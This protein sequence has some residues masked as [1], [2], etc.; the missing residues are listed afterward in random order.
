MFIESPS[1]AA[2]QRGATEAGT[3]Q[4]RSDTAAEPLLSVRNLNVQF[5]SNDR[6]LHIVRDV[7]YDVHAGELVA[8]V[9]E[10][11]C[12]KS[13]SSLAVM[14][15]LPDPQTARFSGEVRLAGRDYL[16]LPED[17]MRRLRGRDIAMVFQEPMTS[18]NPLMT[19]GRQ[20]MEPMLEHL[21]LDALAARK[22]A[23]D[24]LTRVGVTDPERRM[25]QYPHEFSGGMRQRVVIAIALSCNPKV[26]IADEPTT[27]LDVT[28]QAQILDLL[29]SLVKETGVGLVL[30]THNLALVARYADR[31][32][33][34]YGGRIVESGSVEEVL[35]RPRHRYTAGL[36]MA[37]P[38]LDQPRQARL[39]T[40]PGQPPSPARFPAGCAFSPRCGAATAACG[41]VPTDT[42]A[43]GRHYAC[44]HPVVDALPQ[45]GHPAAAGSERSPGETVLSVRGLTRH[46]P[47]KRGAVVRAAEDVSFDIPQGGTL[48]LV[49]E[50]GCG[51][52][53]VVRTLLRLQ[54]A[55]GGRA[56]FEGRDI[57]TA[58]KRDLLALRRQIQVVYQD[59][60][61]SLNPR[62]R[63]GSILAEP[64]LVHGICKDQREARTRVEEL[65]DLVGLPAE[66]AERYPH[67]MSGGQRQRV[68]I[69]RALGMSPRLIVCDEPVS[70]LDVSIQAQIMNLL[71]DLQA[72]LGL[73][74]LFVAHDLA[75]VRHISDV[76]AV[77]YLGRVVETATRA[78]LFS[79]PRHPYTKALLAA[80]PSFAADAGAPE[81]KI[82]GELPSPL[83]PPSGCVFRT[84]CP[85]AV[86]ACGKA[87]PKSVAFSKTHHAACIRV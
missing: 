9:G 56:D 53:T 40:I 64:L 18:L 65:L 21:G 87:V 16:R 27:A 23:V 31:V 30:I 84:R 47:L 11:G 38:R 34:M 73:S 28:I 29:R 22:R 32:N 10:S 86:E 79:N 50:S 54:D 33:V 4:A 77:M 85:M 78:E 81:A 19:V 67:Q 66:M 52:T 63:I 62:H 5:R 71:A 83:N 45:D 6:L 3:M 37:V 61:T 72:K 69:A 24:L 8:L 35:R 59:P 36:L 82:S 60:S 68:G 76:V 17:A 1:I 15:L 57:L 44:F 75:V 12:G 13:V 7:S 48:G 80:V 20:I 74:Y 51:K 14:R 26:I 41:S 43:G 2:L 46:F 55:T 39:H 58:G 49:G 70:A 42:V 25:D